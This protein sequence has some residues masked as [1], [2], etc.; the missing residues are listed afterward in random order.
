MRKLAIA[1][2]AAGALVAA[3]PASAQVYLGADP[4]GRSVRRGVSIFRIVPLP[5]R[6]PVTCI[7][8]RFSAGCATARIFP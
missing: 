5:S 3:V 6:R 8:S 1:A 4:G 2:A 7:I